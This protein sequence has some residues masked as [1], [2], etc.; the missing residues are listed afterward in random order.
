MRNVI[1]RSFVKNACTCTIYKDGKLSDAVI[2]IPCGYNDNSTAERYIRRNNLVDGKL[3][4][5]T[6]ID[7]LSALYGMEESDFIRLAKKVDA[8]SKE[9]RDSITKTVITKRATMLYMTPERKIESCEINL[10][11]NLGK[12]ELAKELAKLLPNG[13]KFIDLDNMEEVETL[14]A[15]DEQTFISN[16]RKMK[17]HFHFEG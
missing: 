4:E 3:V 17:D 12:R 5:V 8:R 13:C 15:L 6:K 1:T 7:K 9:T 14:Y 16:S 10:A 2:I 11:V